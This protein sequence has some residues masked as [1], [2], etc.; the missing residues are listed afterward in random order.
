MR[1]IAFWFIATGSVFVTIGMVGG[2]AMSIAADHT[3][4]PAH[5]HLNLV[6]WVTMALFGFYY[7]LVPAAGATSLARIH[8]AVATIG[9]I[10]MIP[11]IMFAIVE[12]GELLAKVGSLLSLASMLIFVF[13]VLRNRT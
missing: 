12:Q 8:F 4:A 3:F 5:A 1:G 11:G 9:V 2:I 6:G 10:T 13:T 7:H